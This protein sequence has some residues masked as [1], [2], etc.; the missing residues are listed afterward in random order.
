M[1]W[2]WEDS[3]DDTEGA[4]R[5]PGGELARLTNMTIDLSGCL[6]IMTRT[7]PMALVVIS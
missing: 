6:A 1:W 4:A 7:L 3:F 5:L 2:R